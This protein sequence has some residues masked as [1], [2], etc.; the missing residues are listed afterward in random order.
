MNENWKHSE[1]IGMRP[2]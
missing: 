2:N 1:A